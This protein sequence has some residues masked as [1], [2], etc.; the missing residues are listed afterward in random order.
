[1]KIAHFGFGQQ[2][3]TRASR[4]PPAHC[5][6]SW[7]AASAHV[8]RVSDPNYVANLRGT[9]GIDPSAPSARNIGD[10]RG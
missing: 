7:P 5:S 3:L 8:A 1:M 4:K 6:T 9:L 10:A 2:A